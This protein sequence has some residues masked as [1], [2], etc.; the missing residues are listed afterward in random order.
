MLRRRSIPVAQLPHRGAKSRIV[1]DSAKRLASILCDTVFVYWGACLLVTDT[2]APTRRDPRI[3]FFRGLALYMVLFDHVPW[4][5]IGRVTFRN[6]GFSDAAYI[7]FFSSG[8][9]C[10]I[11]FS[12]VLARSGW[13][14]LMKAIAKR[15]ARI[16][17]YYVLCSVVII[18]LSVTCFRPALKSSRPLAFS[19]FNPANSRTRNPDNGWA[20]LACAPPF[21]F[22]YLY[23]PNVD[24][25]PVVFGGRKV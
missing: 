13:L 6:F 7:F 19:S 4:D 22:G 10:G 17:F 14:G 21:R 1:W 5:P 24:R 18:I 25:S 23:Y 8:I 12:R 11:T 15:A 2:T 16:Y 20:G 3:D 9:S